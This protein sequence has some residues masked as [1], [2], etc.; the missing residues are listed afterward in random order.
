MEIKIKGELSKNF[1]W[2][3][4]TQNNDKEY[5]F[6]EFETKTDYDLFVTFVLMLEK[7]RKIIDNK[8]VITS[9]YRPEYYND[10]VLI[11][12][13][14]KSSKKSKHK[15]GVAIDFNFTKSG[16]PLKRRKEIAEIWKNLCIALNFNYGIGFYDWGLHLDI[17]EK[18]SVWDY[19][20]VK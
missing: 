18:N 3:E 9:W 8:I 19:R 11:E 14:Y 15:K 16:I 13:G 7:L 2:E 6:L 12:K 20:T 1:S 4:V 5:R 17:R 10:V